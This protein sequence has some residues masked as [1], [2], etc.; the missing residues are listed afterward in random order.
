MRR[1]V[2]ERAAAERGEPSRGGKPAKLQT[3]LGWEAR[4]LG[5]VLCLPFTGCGPVCS[6]ICFWLCWVFIAACG[7]VVM[8]GFIDVCGLLTAVTSRRRAGSIG[9]QSAVVVAHGLGCSA[10]CGIVL[11]QGLDPRPLR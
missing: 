6:L 7:L 1:L 3:G 11:D 9:T 5:L 8:R 2:A 10:A 4:A